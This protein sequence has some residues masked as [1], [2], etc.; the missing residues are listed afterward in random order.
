MK[1]LLSALLIVSIASSLSFAQSLEDIKYSVKGGI[2]YSS[3]EKLP[4]SI[5]ETQAGIGFYGGAS[6]SYPISD[7]LSVDADILYSMKTIKYTSGATA[8]LEQKN[9]A[10]EVPVVL[11][12]KATDDISVFGGGYGSYLLSAE[13]NAVDNKSSFKTLDYGIILGGSYTYDAWN[14]GASYALG[15]NNLSGV[16]TNEV[17]INN[18]TGSVSYNF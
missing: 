16:D 8:D 7:E 14:F 3:A 13:G 10:V 15:L 1:K 11:N 12:Y 4:A 5:T 9:S 2:N 18:I 6:A 17:K